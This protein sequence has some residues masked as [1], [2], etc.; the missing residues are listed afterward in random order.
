MTSVTMAK[1]RLSTLCCAA[2]AGIRRSSCDI[3]CRPSYSQVRVTPVV[4]SVSSAS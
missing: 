4:E 1:S 3:G 2:S